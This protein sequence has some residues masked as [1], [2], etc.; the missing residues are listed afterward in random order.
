MLAQGNF[1]FSKPRAIIS[2][3][4]CDLPVFRQDTCLVEFPAVFAR[5]A[6]ARGNAA[7]GCRKA[8]DVCHP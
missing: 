7:G 2:R 4:G 8:A 3:L 5:G 6:A 1:R